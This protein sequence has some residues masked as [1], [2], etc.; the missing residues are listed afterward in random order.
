MKTEDRIDW[1]IPA[2][3]TGWQVAPFLFAKVRDTAYVVIP[4]GHDGQR[5]P[6]P[7]IIYRGANTRVLGGLAKEF[8]A[9]HWGTASLKDASS[10]VLLAL[11]AYAAKVK[12][13]G[14]L[15]AKDVIERMLPFTAKLAIKGGMRP[16]VLEEICAPEWCIEVLRY[17][18]L[19]VAEYDVGAALTS[20][21]P[22]DLHTIAAE[23]FDVRSWDYAAIYNL[24]SPLV[25]AL[26]ER[27][28][29]IRRIRKK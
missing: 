23:K 19:S 12:L 2:G 20:A 16:E 1:Q 26:Q 27:N 28:L 14:L 5:A 25:R 15:K 8:I 17:H 6:T 11:V 18:G 29:N 13:Q 10:S 3:E 9:H 7:L 21:L 24:S 22:H 4:L